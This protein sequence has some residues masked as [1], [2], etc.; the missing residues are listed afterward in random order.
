[1]LLTRNW[2]SFNSWDDCLM[3]GQ[4]PGDKRCL[5]LPQLSTS[6]TDYLNLHQK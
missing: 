4:I 5:P 3:N 1:M 6:P 2:I